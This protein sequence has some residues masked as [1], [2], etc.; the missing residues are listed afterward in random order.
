MSQWFHKRERVEALTIDDRALQYGDGL[1]ETIAVRHGDA[2]LM[3][4]HMERLEKGCQRL[5]I[6]MPDAVILQQDLAHAIGQSHELAAYCVAKI[7]VSSGTSQRGY[8]RSQAASPTVLIGVFPA[9]PVS[10]HAY[11][12]GVDTIRCETRLATGS[13]TAGLKTLNRIEQVLGRSECLAAGIFEGFMLDADDRLICGT[14][15]NVF[16]ATDQKIVTPALRRCGVEGVMRR[17]AIDCLRDEGIEVEERDVTFD[18][19]MA[20]DEIFLTNSQFGALPVSD[21][22]GMARKP[23]DMTK[24]VLRALARN[25]ITECAA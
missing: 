25:G 5:Q 18:D 6:A 13:A 4:L 3:D 11:R 9:R 16:M 21:I 2:R 19:C 20:A 23:G 10:A 17:F 7:I 22:G 8:G 14:M 12:D 24:L 15:S 1:F